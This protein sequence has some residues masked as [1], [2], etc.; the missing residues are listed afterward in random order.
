ML[1]SMLRSFAKMLFLVGEVSGLVLPRF[2][3]GGQHSAYR[4]R[5]SPMASADA[6]YSIPDQAERWANAKSTKDMRYIDINTV[7]DGASLKGKRIL[8][9]G[10]NQG[11]GLQLTKEMVAQGADVVVVGRR[12]SDELDALPNVQVAARWQSRP[13][14]LCVLLPPWSFARIRAVPFTN[15]GDHGRRRHGHRGHEVENVA[16]DH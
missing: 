1:N 2:L 5:R 8:I 4:L 10:G 11:L 3:T 12:S 7:Y 15:A 14:D 16:G 13:R 9:T 6:Q